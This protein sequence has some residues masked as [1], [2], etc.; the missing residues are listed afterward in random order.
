METI[1]QNDHIYFSIILFEN[2]EV[3]SNLAYLHRVDVFERRSWLGGG[4]GTQISADA[5][6][7][8]YSEDFNLSVIVIWV[9]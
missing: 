1:T 7:K 6:G 9:G 4:L 2:H 8:L 3:L 5:Q